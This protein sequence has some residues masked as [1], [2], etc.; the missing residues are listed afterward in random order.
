MKYPNLSEWT[1]RNQ[2]LVLYLLLA[3]LLAGAMAYLDLPEKEDPD[4]TFKVMT[5][6]VN[7][8]VRQRGKWSNR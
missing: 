6:S 4:F 7:G 8:P 5:V 2:P 3:L 1:I